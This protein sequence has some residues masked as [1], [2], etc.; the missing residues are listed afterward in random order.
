MPWL[1]WVVSNVLLALLLALAAWF[2]QRWLR[3]PG[4]AH[5]LWVLVL[6]KLVTPPLVSV[7]L[8]QSPLP[9]A[10]QNGTCRC[11]T[12]VQTAAPDTLPRILLAA[13]LTGA[14]ATALTAWRRWA[15]LRHLVAHADPAPAEWQALAARLAAGLSLRRPP[16]VLAVPGRLPPLV[17][18]G[19]RRPRMLLPAALMGRLN[20]RQRTVLMLHELIHVKRRDHLVR[21]LELAVRVAY[22]WL[23][24]VGLVS[25]HL[26]T[27]EEAC[28]DAAVVARQPQARRDYARLLLDVLDFVAPLPRAVA[29]ATAMNSAHDLERRL[30]AILGTGPGTPRGWPVGVLAVGLACAVVPCEL[31]YDWVRGLAPAATSAGQEPAADP[32][33]VPDGDRKSFPSKDLCCCPS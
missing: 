16:E 18:P 4:I 8:Q 19:W 3:W 30:R 2:V 33:P 13:W 7:P 11:G 15:R 17:V 29:H 6:V 12:H 10:C 27:C 20:R 1:S 22:W 24:V 21:L 9:P 32:T 5:T 28:C 14:A 31:Q 23:P 26:R 25:R